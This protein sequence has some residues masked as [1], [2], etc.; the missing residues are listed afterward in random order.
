RGGDRHVGVEVV[1]ERDVDEIDVLAIDRRAPVGR[2]LFPLPARGHRLERARIAAAQERAPDTEPR[3]VEMADLGKGVGVRLGHEALAE[4]CDA[5]LTHVNAE[6]GML[7]AEN[8]ECHSAF[9]IRHHSAVLFRAVASQPSTRFCCMASSAS[10]HGSAE[11]YPTSSGAF[12]A[13]FLAFSLSRKS[14][15]WTWRG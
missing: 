4:Q 2:G 1:R 14:R 12:V 10:R 8:D 5:E 13:R 11:L 6:C 9:N 15:V 3:G 7:N